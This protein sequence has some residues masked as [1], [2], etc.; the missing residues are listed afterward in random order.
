VLQ[1][2]KSG[3]RD[4]IKAEYI[5]RLLNKALWFVAVHRITLAGHWWLPDSA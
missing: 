4:F 3:M 1:K 2:Q 5:E